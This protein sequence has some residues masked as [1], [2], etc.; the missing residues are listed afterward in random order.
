MSQSKLP[1][2]PQQLPLP[3][4]SRYQRRRRPVSWWGIVI[5]LVA[6][7]VASLYYAWMLAPVREF[8][9]T[10][11]Q[12]RASD[13]AQYAIAIALQ[14]AFDSD[15]NVAVQRLIELNIGADPFQAVADVACDLAR[16]G[17]VDST[18]GLRAV[19]RLKVFYQ[20][21]GKTGCADQLI[22]DV[23]TASVVDVVIPT[24]T[25]TLPPPPSKTPLLDLSPTPMGVVLVPTTRPRRVYQGRIVGTYCDAELTGII[26]VYVQNF[27]G[28]PVKGERVRVR[29]DGGEDSFVT[30]LKPERGENYADFTM[31]IGKSYSVDMPTLSDPLSNPL[32]ADACITDTGQSAITSYRVVFTQ[33]S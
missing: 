31:E 19:R 6:G 2:P 20:L 32:V 15:L 28:D 23:E 26:E 30:G 5:G 9:T 1:P 22:P 12:L 3:R 11:R 33:T 13:K 8:D 10:P 24:P 4:D 29:W 21:Q 17:Y 25:A 27:Q 7:V 14:F 16:G 18:T